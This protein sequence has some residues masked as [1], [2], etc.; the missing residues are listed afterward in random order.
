[1]MTWQ[2]IETA[3]KDQDVLLWVEAAMGHFYV[4]IGRWFALRLGE[5]AGFWSCHAIKVRTAYWMPLPAP[6]D[7]PRL[8]VVE[9]S[10]PRDE[11]PS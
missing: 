11:P 4:D 8:S 5:D 3:P 10:A 6:P 9:R 7:P 1:M 2:P